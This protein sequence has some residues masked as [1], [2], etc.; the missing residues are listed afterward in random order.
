MMTIMMVMIMMATMRKS[1]P[2]I[3]VVSLLLILK[4][5][6][7]SFFYFSDSL[8]KYI[9]CDSLLIKYGTLVLQPQWEYQQYN[10]EHQQRWRA[11]FSVKSANREST[12]SW[13]HSATVSSQLSEVCQFANRNSA[14]FSWLIRKSQVQISTWT[15]FFL[16]KIITPYMV[17]LLGEKFFVRI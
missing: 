9:S 5:E 4:R 10:V 17:Y 3:M 13:A 15:I 12:I 7:N 11:N 6:Q 16:N 1:L 14:K 2:M 8:K